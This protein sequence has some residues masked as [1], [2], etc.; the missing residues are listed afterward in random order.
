[1]LD[2][3]VFNSIEELFKYR[4]HKNKPHKHNGKQALEKQFNDELEKV[5]KKA[6]TELDFDVISIA[7]EF[8]LLYGRCDFVVELQDDKYVIIESKAKNSKSTDKTDDLRFCY[9][10]GQLQTYRTIFNIQYKIPKENVYL[11]LATN[12]DSL[13]V[14]SLL[15]AE[16]LDIGYLIYNEMGVK[17]YGKKI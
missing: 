12:Y 6:L 14:H 13:L 16:N 5:L 7:R 1:M 9:S 8:N 2:K 11:M 17:Y 3:K 15:G 10:V 4:L